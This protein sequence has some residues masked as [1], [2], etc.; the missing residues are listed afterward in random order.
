MQHTDFI[1][2]IIAEETGFVGCTFLIIILA[3]FLYAGLHISLKLQDTFASLTTAGLVLLISLQSIIN[4]AVANGILPTKGIGLPF[5]SYG[6]S[7]LIAHLIMVGII[8]RFVH[9]EK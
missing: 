4:I 9:H 8:V 7:A 1:F 2:S 6:N 5:V 3:V